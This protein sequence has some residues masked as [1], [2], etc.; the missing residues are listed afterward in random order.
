VASEINRLRVSR[1]ANTAAS[2]R[3]LLFIN[4]EEK[5][6]LHQLKTDTLE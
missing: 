4:H 6:R 3:R 2:A 1:W 5:V